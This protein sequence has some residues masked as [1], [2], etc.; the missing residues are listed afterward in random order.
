MLLRLEAA[1]GVLSVAVEHTLDLEGKHRAVKD[2]IVFL[3]CLR[4]V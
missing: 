4:S 2:L 3:S 1:A